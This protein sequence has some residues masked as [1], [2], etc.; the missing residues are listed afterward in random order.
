MKTRLMIVVLGV[1]LG[2]T[3]KWIVTAWQASNPSPAAAQSD[4]S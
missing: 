4:D 1:A 2:L 3:A